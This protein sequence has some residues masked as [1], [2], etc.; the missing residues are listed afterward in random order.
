MNIVTNENVLM[1]KRCPS[2]FRYC[3][4]SKKRGIKISSEHP[5]NLRFLPVGSGEL[6]S[7]FCAYKNGSYVIY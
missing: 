6:T 5:L 3:H 7:A 4:Y 2:V 1:C